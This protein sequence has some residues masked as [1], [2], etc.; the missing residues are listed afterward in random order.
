[1]TSEAVASVPFRPG[2]DHGTEPAMLE[3]LAGE[4]NR[5]R[6]ESRAFRSDA[7]PWDLWYLIRFEDVTAAFRDFERFSSRQTN[8]NLDDP[9]RWIPAQIDPPDHHPYRTA[10]N[11]RFSHA[12]ARRH[13]R[14]DDQ[15]VAD[16]E[17]NRHCAF[18]VGVHRCVGSHL[19]RLE[20]G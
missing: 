9:R 7:H 11:P 6:E 5:L 3:H 18:G 4:W 15:F 13:E 10:I 20:C 16:R 12:V 8:Y 17:I 14:R 1:M 2:F 19:A